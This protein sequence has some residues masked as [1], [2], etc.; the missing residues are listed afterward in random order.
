MNYDYEDL[1]KDAARAVI[2][3]P[4]LHIAELLDVLRELHD[5][6]GYPAMGGKEMQR[7]SRAM[8]RANKLLKESE[9]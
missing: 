7:Y 4:N 5:F 9:G 2:K 8:K 6:S 1:S 3:E